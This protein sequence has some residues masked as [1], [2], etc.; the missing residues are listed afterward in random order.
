MS[1]RA[2]RV[3][4]ILRDLDLRLGSEEQNEEK[5]KKLL[6]TN[7][8]KG[9]KRIDSIEKWYEDSKTNYKKMI[10]RHFKVELTDDDDLDSKLNKLLRDQHLKV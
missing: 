8:Y 5:L 6:D 7:G 2:N 4:A 9:P 3:K 10:L 1:N